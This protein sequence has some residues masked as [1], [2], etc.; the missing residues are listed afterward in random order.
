[1]GSDHSSFLVTKSLLFPVVSVT[2]TPP[3][4][5]GAPLACSRVATLP[6]GPTANA[7][8]P[9][10]GATPLMGDAV[11]V[12]IH[13]HCVITYTTLYEGDLKRNIH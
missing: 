12:S 4:Q 1:M 9:A 3:A 7:A 6:W 8:P 11:N 5:T 10:T 2:G 13:I